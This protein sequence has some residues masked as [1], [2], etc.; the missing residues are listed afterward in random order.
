MFGTWP[1]MWLLYWDI[2]HSY[3]LTGGLCNLGCFWRT[4]RM[5]KTDNDK[6]R[7]SYMNLPCWDQELSQGSSSHDRHYRLYHTSVIKALFRLHTL[8]QSKA[9]PQGENARVYRPCCLLQCHMP[10]NAL[11]NLMLRKG[12]AFAMAV[13]SV[14]DTAN[15]IVFLEYFLTSWINHFLQLVGSHSSSSS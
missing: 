3:L 4:N 1:K 8:D 2:T 5:T 13:T 7:V 12:G 14:I 11:C 10:Q 9:Q 15:S 6:D